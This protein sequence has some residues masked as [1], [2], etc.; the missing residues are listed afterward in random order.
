MTA[1]DHRTNAIAAGTRTVV[2]VARVADGLRALLRSMR[3]R[4]DLNRLDALSDHE[5]ADIGLQRTDLVSARRA[6]FGVDPTAQL[7][8]FARRRYL[9]EDGARRIC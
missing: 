8:D 2:A 7:S 4:R 5:L 9:S 1:L 6:A 3:H